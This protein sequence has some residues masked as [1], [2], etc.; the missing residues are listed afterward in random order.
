MGHKHTP[1]STSSIK[2]AFFLN[3]CFTVIEVIGG[4][5]TNSLAILADSLHDLGDSFSLG[6]SWYLDKY[7]K[8]KK[9]KRYSYGY[10]RFSLLGALVNTIVLIAGSLFVLSEA[11][12]RLFQPEHSNA[13]GMALLAVVGIIV[14]GIAV[15]RVKG[16]KTLNARVIAWHLLEDVLGWAAVLAVSI[17]LLFKDI[18]ILDPILSILIMLYILFNVIGNLKKTL[19]LFLQAVP[20]D[21]DVDKIEGELLSINKVQSIHHTHVWSLDGENHVLTMH[22]VVDNN[23]SKNEVLRIK[24][25]IDEITESIN[26]EHSTVEIEYENEYCRMKGV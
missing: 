23:T 2:A 9:D 10:R 12:P 22:V 4:I 1:G 14:N 3:L 25:E 24:G 8:K 11:I 26:F 13:Q 16:S 15:L 5:W 18:H 7:S 6:L 19:S 20:E 17:I 21:I